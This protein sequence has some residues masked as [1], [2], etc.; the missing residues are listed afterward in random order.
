MGSGLR[1]TISSECL[2]GQKKDYLSLLRAFGVVSCDRE[3]V[4]SVGV[5]LTPLHSAALSALLS[6]F[7][8]LLCAS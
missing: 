4:L 5:E 8:F 6:T 7:Y 1:S 3:E 2:C